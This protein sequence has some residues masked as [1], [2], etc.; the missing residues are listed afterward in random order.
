MQDDHALGSRWSVGSM[1]PF[2][3]EFAEL[4]AWRRDVR[5]FRA[6]AIPEATL[7]NLFRLSAFAPS[8]G[9]CQPT[10][11]V[12]VSARCTRFGWPPAPTALASVGCRSSIRPPSRFRAN[13]RSSAISALDGC[14]RST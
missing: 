9:N 2:Q 1:R 10:R 3:A 12:R 8:V 4:L 11:F 5:R 13:G 14:R 6:G 7:E